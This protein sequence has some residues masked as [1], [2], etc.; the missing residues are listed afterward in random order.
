MTKISESKTAMQSL[1]F[2]SPDPLQVSERENKNWNEAW[3]GPAGRSSGRKDHT[4]KP[5][6]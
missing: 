6:N 5:G 1:Q 2:K 3:Y 4:G